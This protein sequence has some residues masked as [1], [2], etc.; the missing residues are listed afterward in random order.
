MAP[1]P[2][3]VIRLS[4]Y[5][6]G[7]QR[8]PDGVDLPVD[9]IDTHARAVGAIGVAVYV[10]LA[11]YADPQTGACTLDLVRIARVLGIAPTTVTTALQ[12]LAATGLITI[13]ERGADTE[14]GITQ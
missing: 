11:R 2:R 1:R 13:E 4:D 6:E 5:P 3:T 10:A 8:T 14:T 12:R 9:L 7:L